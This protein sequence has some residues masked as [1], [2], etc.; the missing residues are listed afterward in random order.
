MKANEFLRWATSAR[1][2]SNVVYH[3]GFL[4]SDCDMSFGAASRHEQQLNRA[5]R[6]VAMT[7]AR[8]GIV[9]L[10]QRRLGEGLY[11]YVA[12]RTGVAMP[13]Q[14]TALASDIREAL[15]SDNHAALAA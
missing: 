14:V 10:V 5:I 7:L 13:I 15:R 6:R 4:A 2:G 8:A 12:Q 3:R 1:R 11:E 9:E